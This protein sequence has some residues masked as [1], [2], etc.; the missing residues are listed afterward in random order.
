MTEAGFREARIRDVQ[1]LFAKPAWRSMVGAKRSR[2]SDTVN[3]TV[4]PSFARE[5]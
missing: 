1:M 3:S 5:G 4:R 2:S